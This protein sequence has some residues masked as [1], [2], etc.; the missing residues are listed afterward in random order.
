M[1]GLPLCPKQQWASF[2]SKSGRAPYILLD[3]QQKVLLSNLGLTVF[4]RHLVDLVKEVPIVCLQ[5]R[6]S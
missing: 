5:G 4:A 6:K 1:S 3:R 2:F